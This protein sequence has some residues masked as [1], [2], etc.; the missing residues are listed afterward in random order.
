MHKIFFCSKVNLVKKKFKKSVISL[1]YPSPKRQTGMSNGTSQADVKW[2]FSSLPMR[3]SKTL[4][5]E[6]LKS[7]IN[8]SW[9]QDPTAG[10]AV[11]NP[12]AHRNMLVCSVSSG[13]TPV[14]G[15]NW[16]IE[17]NNCIILTIKIL[18][19]TNQSTKKIHTHWIKALNVKLPK[20]HHYS[21]VYVYLAT[22]RE[23]LK[24]YQLSSTV[25]KMS[26]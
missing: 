2:N 9:H 8:Y 18:Y 20:N 26:C 11:P 24:V 5:T 3:F 10:V 13:S 14:E 1:I 15:R 21:V 22:L 25:F 6:K 7:T 19:S 12:G 4:G 23:D 16:V 17:R